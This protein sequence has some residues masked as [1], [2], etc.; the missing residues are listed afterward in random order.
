VQLV[1]ML[2]QEDYRAVST[3]TTTSFL[4]YTIHVLVSV[5]GVDL[6]VVI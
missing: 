1:P 4:T 2:L 6:R 5:H 3:S